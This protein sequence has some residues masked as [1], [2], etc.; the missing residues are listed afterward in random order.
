M[1]IQLTQAMNDLTATH[2]ELL[3]LSK[4]KTEALTNNKLDEFQALLLQ[5]P[6]LVRKLEA[7]EAKRQE[8]VESW[9]E[10]QSPSANDLTITEILNRLDEEEQKT[11]EASAIALTDA[12][13]DLKRQEQLNKALLEESM[14]FVQLS[15]ELINPSMQSMNYGAA[16]SGKMPNRSLFDSKA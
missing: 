11:V 10:R 15:M 8:I 7:Q 6:K 14:K 1:T 13:T 9:N 12:I 5:Q 16:S 3:E 4:Q 2:K